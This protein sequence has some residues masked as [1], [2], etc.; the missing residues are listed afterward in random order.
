MVV[1]AKELQDLLML[2]PYLE[3][4]RL[5]GPQKEVVPP[6]RVKGGEDSR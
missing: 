2:C 3:R 5:R 1:K 4:H 6:G